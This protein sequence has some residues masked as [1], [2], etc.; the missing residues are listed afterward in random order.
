M[1]AK[2]ERPTA[3]LRKRAFGLWLP[4]SGFCI[5]L[6][7]CSI[8]M[9][10]AQADPTRFFVLQPAIQA[11]RGTNKEKPLVIRIKS[12]DVPGY[13]RDK[14]V[15]VRRGGNEVRY[16]DL[17]RW[18]EPLDQGLVRSLMLG[19][20]SFSDVTVV[21]RQQAVEKWDYDLTIQV[22]ACEGTE[23]EGVA[24][25]ANWELIPAA[26]SDGR[27]RSGTLVGKDLTWDGR[28]PESLVAGFSKGVTQLC[29]ALAEALKLRRPE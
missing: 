29:D 22:V 3:Q 10:P 9:P 16:L 15:A 23:G 19:L 24:F 13:L 25:T 8:P 7:G 17:A 27:G 20:G 14:P 1:Q 11:P 2:I 5:L 26:G 6:A 12:V 21:S 18:A 28:S 4:A